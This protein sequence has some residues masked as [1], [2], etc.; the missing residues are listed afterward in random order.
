[1]FGL[2]M[3]MKEIGNTDFSIKGDILKIQNKDTHV[4]KYFPIGELNLWKL[5]L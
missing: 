2:N 5:P 4:I 1:M 3:M